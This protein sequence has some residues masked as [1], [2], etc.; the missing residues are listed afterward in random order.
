[1]EVR[2]SDG[3]AARDANG[4]R[5]SRIMEV[6]RL[7]LLNS[8]PSP[9]QLH[10]SALCQ[11]PIVGSTPSAKRHDLGVGGDFVGINI[12]ARAGRQTHRANIAM[13]EKGAIAVSFSPSNRLWARIG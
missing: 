7:R 6:L 9:E 2:Y 5:R 3:D 1:M 12:S 10:D 8:Q 11:T 4:W 13:N